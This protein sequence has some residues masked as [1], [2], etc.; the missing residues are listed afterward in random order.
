MDY[1]KELMKS[2]NVLESLR[3]R[4]GLLVAAPAR[5]TG[6]ANAWIRDNVYEAMGLEAIA[7][8]P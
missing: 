6:Y 1:K 3:V 5:E 8:F 7:I 2:S 4:C